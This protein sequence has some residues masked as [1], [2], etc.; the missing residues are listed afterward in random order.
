MPR[1]FAAVELPPAIREELG[2]L[3]ANI[4]S[5]R[6]VKPEQMHITLRFVGADVPASQVAPIQDA[7]AT[8]AGA[9]FWLT[10]RGV[11]RFPPAGRRP[12]R[13][14]W[15]GLDHEPALLDL[16]RRV[17]AA[18]NLVGFAP[19]DRPFNAHITLARLNAREPVPQ[20]E[21]FLRAHTD[22]AAGPFPVEQFVLLQSTLTP[23]GARYQPLGVYPLD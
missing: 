4:P 9:A 18:L 16:H 21:R 23:Q 14:L 20:V 11:G 15:V 13:V 3:R 19:E 6:W 1:L 5:A 10:L 12:A 17:E 2:G 8:V 7:L 22:F